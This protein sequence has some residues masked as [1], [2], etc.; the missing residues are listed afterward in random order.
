MN[1]K[2]QLALAIAAVLSSPLSAQT[3]SGIVIDK[4][5]NP[6]SKA[7]IS[8]TNSK[9]YSFADEQGRFKL[10]D[11][12]SGTVQ[13]HVTAN[14]FSH[15]DQSIEV[16][17]NNINQLNIVLSPTVFDI[18]NINATPLHASSVESVL[19]VNVISGQDLKMKQASTLGGK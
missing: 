16:G 19:P 6:V 3:I 12:D 4:A 5:G 9:K 11:I 13:L 2:T 15:V 17:A 14:S 8:V 1:K 18:I 7:K 10:T